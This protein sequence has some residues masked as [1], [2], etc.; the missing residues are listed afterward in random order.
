M[1]ISFLFSLQRSLFQIYAT[2]ILE[3]TN[4]HFKPNLLQNLDCSRFQP[5]FAQKVC[6]FSA[7]LLASASTSPWFVLISK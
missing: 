6:K 5:S 4:D 7:Q 3:V 1:S 2:N